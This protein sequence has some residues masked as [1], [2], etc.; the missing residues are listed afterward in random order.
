MRDTLFAE[1][2]DSVREGGAMLKN[3]AT[4]ARSSASKNRQRSGFAKGMTSRR[5]EN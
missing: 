4:P 1:L 2:I 3:R 5:P